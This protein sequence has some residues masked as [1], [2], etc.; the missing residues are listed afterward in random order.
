MIRWYTSERRISDSFKSNT[1]QRHF[2]WDPTSAL[3]TTV[4]ADGAK[5]KS[6]FKYTMRGGRWRAVRPPS[7]QTNPHCWRL[8]CESTTSR[9]PAQRTSDVKK[10]HIS[11]FHY[12]W[13][14]L[15]KFVPKSNNW[16][17]IWHITS[18]NAYCVRV[19]LD[20]GSRSCLQYKTSLNRQ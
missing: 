9:F 2:T 1:T 18:A 4:I 14:I 16:Q 5:S 20:Y 6:K 12:A 15:I 19:C 3:V 7:A 10:S 8:C 13:C 17:L 11:W